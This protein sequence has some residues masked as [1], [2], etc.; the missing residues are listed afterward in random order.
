MAPRIAEGHRF[1]RLVLERLHASAR[2]GARPRPPGPAPA[3]RASSASGRG[4]RR[5]RRPRASARRAGEL[6]QDRGVERALAELEDPTAGATRDRRDHRHLVAV[7]EAVVGIGV[8]A[9]A[10]EA[11]RRR[12]PAPRTGKRVTSARPGRLDVGP[13]GQLDGHLARPG[14][15][16]LDREQPDPDPDGHAGRR[17]SA[18]P[19]CDEQAV[20]DRQDRRA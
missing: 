9:V 15:L 1:V 19:R 5:P 14:Q 17:P 20:A 11:D 8:V 18:E 6:G 7:G 10:R 3:S 2:R 16:A 13:V 12:G 4:T